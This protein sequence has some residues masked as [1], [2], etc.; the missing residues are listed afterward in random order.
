M[1]NNTVDNDMFPKASTVV[2]LGPTSFCQ[3]GS[4]VLTGNCGGV[5]N[6]GETTESISVTNPGTYYTTNT[7]TCGAAVSNSILVTIF[8]NPD[9]LITGINTICAGETTQLCVA[10]GYTSYLWSTGDATNCIDVST[11]GTYSVT[12]TNINGCTSMC[13]KDVLV[14]SS[15]PCTI[16]GGNSICAGQSTT[17]CV[18]IGAAG[19]LW[20]TLETTNCI[21]V[22]T[23]GL[24]SVTVT[25][26]TGCTS[27]CS[28][29]ISVGA[30]PACSITGNDLI[31]LGQST[32]LCA[33]PG[34]TSYLWSN[35]ATTSCITVNAIGT[36]SITITNALGC[37]SE[38]SI[39]ISIVPDNIGPDIIC[40]N[41]ITIQCDASILPAN[42]GTA[43]ATDN[44]TA[45]PT[46][47]YTTITIP[48]NCN[49]AYTLVRTWKATDLSG[50][51]SVC[52]QSISVIDNIAPIISC[53][54]NLTV[55][56]NTSTLPSITGNATA[57]DNCST[58]ISINYTDQIVPGSCPQAFQILRTWTATDG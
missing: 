2:A 47:T 1:H 9:C 54:A 3:G 21:N 22:I 49:Q 29:T 57:T 42:T 17:I 34:M 5:W 31:C 43:T 55:E 38:C 50:N 32:T 58:S 46:I 19:Y 8:P 37:T 25:S 51:T 16:T 7:N 35:A 11:A 23:P 40:P 33:T 36:Y 41:D 28:K 53:P 44:C 52:D 39:D 13:S 27:V 10:A 26:A 6:T 56:C 45:S 18:P 15:P 14:N 4:V 30:L 12:I 20:N 48:G 24:Y